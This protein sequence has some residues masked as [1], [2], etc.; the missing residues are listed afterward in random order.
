MDI[1]SVSY[2]QAQFYD[3]GI[4]SPIGRLLAMLDNYEFGVCQQQAGSVLSG[5][6]TYM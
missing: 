1:S 5:I 4:S 3:L 2:P 6:H